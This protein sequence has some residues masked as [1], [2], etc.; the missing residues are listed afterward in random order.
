MPVVFSCE[1]A[2]LLEVKT[3]SERETMSLGESLGRVAKAGTVVGLKGELGSGKTR[4]VQGMARG[5]G[6]PEREAVTSPTFSLIHEYVGGR[7]PLYHI[8]L[9]RMEEGDL[10]PELGLD[11]YLEGQGVCAM[12]WAEKIEGFL[13]TDRMEV[14]LSI[15]GPKSRRIVLRALGPMHREVLERLKGKEAFSRA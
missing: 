5:L 8:D 10:D 9:Y 11:E 4:F 2:D 7:L 15:E 13:P 14:T 6:I 1:K 12:E 3:R